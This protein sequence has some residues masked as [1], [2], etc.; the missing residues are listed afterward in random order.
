MQPALVGSPVI[1][2]SPTVLIDLLLKGPKGVLPARSEPAGGDMPAFDTM[3]DGDLAALISYVRERFGKQ[4]PGV[5][6][7]QV[8]ARR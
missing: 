2:G 8:A 7:A 1:A 5:T 3:S 4:A 6:A